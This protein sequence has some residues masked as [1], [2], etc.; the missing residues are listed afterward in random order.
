MDDWTVRP[1]D[2]VHAAVFIDAIVVKVQGDPDRRV[3]RAV[4]DLPVPGGEVLRRGRRRSTAAVAHSPGMSR[5]PAG[6]APVV[7]ARLE[8]AAPRTVVSRAR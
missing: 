5:S 3:E 1:L 7:G 2:A 4:R 8:V 6:P